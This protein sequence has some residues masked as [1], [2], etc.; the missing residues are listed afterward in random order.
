MP[1]FALLPTAILSDRGLTASE[2]RVLGALYSFRSSAADWTV[3]PSRLAIALR[4][5]I[6]HLDSISRTI[7]KLVKRGYVAVTRRQ[8]S[9]I[10][11]LLLPGADLTTGG[12]IRPDVRRSDEEIREET[13]KTPLPP[14]GD[15]VAAIAIQE[16]TPPPSAPPVDTASEVSPALAIAAATAIIEHLNATTGAK[17]DAT[18]RPLIRLVNRRL[19]THTA[20]ELQLVSAYFA[21]L[22][23]GTAMEQHA[24]NPR[25]I[26]APTRIALA[27]SEI[28][29]S[30]QQPAA[31][32]RLWQ[33]APAKP[34]TPE[35]ARGALSGLKR[36]LRC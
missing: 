20:D 17:L 10:Y 9:S 34:T 13:I 36:L 30:Q 29:R 21:A 12:Q 8:T 25:C 15:G 35:T 3:W 14:Q 18:S 26:F 33:P 11:H 16:P 19:K 23:K 22:W 1:T 28:R 32:P 7:A 6:G 5:G 27:L 31:G 24:R 4:C 2:L